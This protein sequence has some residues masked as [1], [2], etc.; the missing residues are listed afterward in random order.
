MEWRVVDWR[1]KIVKKYCNFCGEPMEADAKE[2]KQCGWDVS[3]NGPPTTEP[4]DRK[5]RISV[6]AG[7]IVAYAVV[8]TLIQGTP[9][10]ARADAAREPLRTAAPEFTAE[11]VSEAATVITLPPAIAST[12]APATK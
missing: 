6:A 2:C 11:P 3:H 4:G 7:L 12:P 5:A 9:V 8:W 10:P 1:G